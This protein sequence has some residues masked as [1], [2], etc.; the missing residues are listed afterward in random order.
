[1]TWDRY[2][3]I[4]DQIERQVFRFICSQIQEM[5]CTL[6]AINGMPDHVHIVVKFPTTI[7]IADLVKKVKG[8][9]SRFI[10]SND[11]TS[12][13]FKW[14]IGYGAFTISRW[15]LQKIIYYVR[16]Q[17]KHH[18]EGDLIELIEG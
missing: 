7:S 13:Q 10:N 11:R 6:L 4:A 18:Y 17:K 5:C 16:N 14:Q 9:S 15:D 12:T 3:Y 8:T 2:P 1:M